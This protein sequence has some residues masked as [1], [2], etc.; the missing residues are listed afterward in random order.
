[1]VHGE[2]SLSEDKTQKYIKLEGILEI[3]EF[4]L[5]PCAWIH[6]SAK[7]PDRL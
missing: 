5:F 3:T 1:M 6:F 4:T 2:G 7:M